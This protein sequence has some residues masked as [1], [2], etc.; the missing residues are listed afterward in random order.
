MH[1]SG[2]RFTVYTNKTLVRRLLD[3]CE[4]SLSHIRYKKPPRRSVVQAQK[5][6]AIYLHGKRYIYFK[7]LHIENDPTEGLPVGEYLVM[8]FPRKE[9]KYWVVF[10]HEPK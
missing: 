6:G 1:D 5:D 10:K 7:D 2:W 4:M 9:P 3:A 8:Q